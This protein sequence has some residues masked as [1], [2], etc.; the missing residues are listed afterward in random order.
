M[1]YINLLLFHL[2]K[3]R[4]LRLKADMTCLRLLGE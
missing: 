1:K 3:V 2:L 4:K